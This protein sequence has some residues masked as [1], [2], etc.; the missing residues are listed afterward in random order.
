[1]KL[2]RTSAV[3]I[4]LTDQER[5]SLEHAARLIGIGPSSF[6]RM[7]VVQA[8]GLT[9]APAPPPK[10]QSNKEARELTKFLGELA[11][12]GSN[13]NQIARALNGGWDCDPDDLRRAAAELTKLRAAVL[14]EFGYSD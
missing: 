12:V 6:A 10:R 8:L 2:K 9:P 7:T 13:I 1:M 4:R 3:N 11:R 5:S 14:Q